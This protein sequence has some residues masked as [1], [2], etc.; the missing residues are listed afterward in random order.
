MTS[1]TIEI[2]PGETAKVAIGGQGCPVIGRLIVPGGNMLP[3]DL[4]GGR[5]S[6]SVKVDLP[7]M[8]LPGDF[9]TWSPAAAGLLI[10]LVQVARRESLIPSDARSGLKIESDG[11]FRAEEVLPGSYKLTVSVGGEEGGGGRA[12]QAVIRAT[13][14]RDVLVPVIPGGSTDQPLDLEAL[15]LAVD[16][17]RFKAIEVGRPAPAVATKTLDGKPLSWPTIVAA[18]SCSTSGR[19]GASPAWSRSRASSRRTM[20][21]ARILDSHW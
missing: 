18:T 1:A 3:L 19:P 9:L 7:E 12:E 8:P 5:G 4:A 13:A 20:R 17:T 21:S 6:L 14:K 15:E 2:K 10:R 11:S 16:V